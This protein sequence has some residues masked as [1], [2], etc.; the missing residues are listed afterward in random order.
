MTK[1]R[2]SVAHTHQIR[3]AD[4]AACSLEWIA[5]RHASTH[6]I[7][8]KHMQNENT[9]PSQLGHVDTIPSALGPVSGPSKRRKTTS[10]SSGTA[11]KMLLLIAAV[12]VVAY[13]TR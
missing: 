9:I 10:S 1:V 5:G 6:A 12:M 8:F 7:N 4:Q 11:V 3:L 2:T 13:L